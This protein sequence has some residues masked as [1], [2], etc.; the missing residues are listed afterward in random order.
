MEDFT[1]DFSEVHGKSEPKIFVI[2]QLKLSWYQYRHDLSQ[3]MNAVHH[4]RTKCAES[5]PIS[6]IGVDEAPLDSNPCFDRLA[7]HG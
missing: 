1:E 3:R 4:T 2:I 7:P 6:L 5:V